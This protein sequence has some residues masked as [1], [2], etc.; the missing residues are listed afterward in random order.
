MEHSPCT[1]GIDTQTFLCNFKNMNISDCLHILASLLAVV[2]SGCYVSSAWNHTTLPIMLFRPKNVFTSEEWKVYA[3]LRWPKFFGKLF[4]C[5][6]CQIPW[7]AAALT[8][9]AGVV[10]HQSF[11]VRLWVFAC[12]IGIM[13]LILR[14]RT[15]PKQPSPA[16]APPTPE[17]PDAL[18]KMSK[19]DVAKKYMEAFSIKANAAGNVTLSANTISDKLRIVTPFFSEAPCWFDGCA[20]LRANYQKELELMRTDPNC[21]ECAEGDLMR[22]YSLRVHAKLWPTENAS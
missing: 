17:P 8:T 12:S 13:S 7:I 6:T 21:P 16:K 14:N 3:T 18:D 2:L 19:L 11:P 22:K 1:S 4:T 9:I 20:E 15:S 5:P 10:D